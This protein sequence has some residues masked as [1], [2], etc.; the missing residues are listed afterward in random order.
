MRKNRI[1]F[2]ISLLFFFFGCTEKENKVHWDR[3]MCERCKMVV[4]DRKN[5]VRMEIPITKKYFVFDDIGCF[6]WW[7]KEQNKKWIDGTKVVIND[8]QT[9]E[10]I[11]MKSA[12][13][14]AGNLS[15]M[16]YGFWAYKKGTEP[17]DKEV[18]GY[19]EVRKRII[20]RGR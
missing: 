9:G 11:D 5:T 15:P 2:F 20:A 4:S 10:W 18:L 8:S 13:Y 19:D 14:T 6:I 12:L 7:Q 17:K 1:I 3:D 16:G